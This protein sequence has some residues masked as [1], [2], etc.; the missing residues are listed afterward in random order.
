MAGCCGC[1]GAKPVEQPSREN[2]VGVMWLKFGTAVLLSGLTMYLSLGAN[3]GDPQ[4]VARAVIHGLLMTIAAG[5]MFGLGWPILKS[6]WT[7]LR[8]GRITLEHAFLIG[9]LGSFA[10]SVYSSFTGRGAIYYE[11][12]VILTAIYLFGRNISESLIRKQAT[13]AMAVPGLPDFAQVMQDGVAISIPVDALKTGD[14]VRIP[15]G[16]TIPIDGVIEHGLAYIA[17]Q[18]HTGETSPKPCSPGQKVLAGSVVLDGEILVRA[19]CDAGNRE[20]DRLMA[21]LTAC[22]ASP[23]RAEALARK[24]LRIFVPAVLGTALL[25]AIIWTLLGHPQEGWLNALTVT[26]VACPCAL[27][28]AIPLAV[29]RGRME[30]GLLGIVPMQGDFLDR[31]AEVNHVA[32]DKTGTLSDP[33]LELSAFEIDPAAPPDLSRWVLAI[34]KKSA[35]PVARP[36]WKLV[37]GPA[38]MLDGLRVFNL[39][40]R[41]I[42]AVFRAGGMLR[43]LHLGNRHLLPDL[44]LAIPPDAGERSIHVILD[45]HVVATATLDESA[46]ERSA[47]S[48]KQLMGDGLQVSILTGDSTIPRDYQTDGVRAACGLSSAAKA[49]IVS[50]ADPSQRVLYIGDGLNDCECFRAAHASIALNSG[51][52]AARTVAQ[53]VLLHN[54]LSVIPQA[55]RQARGMRDRL[56]KILRFSFVF[57]TCGVGLAA[58]GLLHPVIAALLMFASSLFVIMRMQQ[59]GR[60]RIPGPDFSNAERVLA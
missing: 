28:V 55:L 39:P 31:L 23:V 53:A 2:P 45:G 29:R 25:T 46:R 7:D 26:V 35:H 56:T 43:E 58:F 34:Q 4:G 10:A 33:E 27:G 5:V 59:S 60:R 30:L 40:G 36:F 6:G 50:R 14:L 11:V 22:D 37:H 47:A 15:E 32:F 42:R 41:G 19:A 24:V 9:I 52:V 51:N 16:G 13:L 21:S 38:E 12:V 3:L 44:G 54:D 48:L 1:A 18:A 20:I 8:R 49:E 57:N 17:Q